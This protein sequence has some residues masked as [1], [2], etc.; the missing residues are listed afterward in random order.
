MKP[1]RSQSAA[2]YLG[3]F[4][5]LCWILAFMAGTDVW[6]DAGRPDFLRLGATRTDLRALAFGFYTLPF[7]LAGQIIVMV[8]SVRRA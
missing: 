1:T 2:L 4:A 7:C 3:V 5:L 8:V 6:H